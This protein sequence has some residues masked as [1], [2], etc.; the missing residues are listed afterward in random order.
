MPIQWCLVQPGNGPRR[1]AERMARVWPAG[2]ETVK[3]NTRNGRLDD[4]LQVRGM[5]DGFRDAE[6]RPGGHEPPGEVVLP[7]VRP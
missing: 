1:Y 5:S 2:D 3:G 7:L 6:R 4:G